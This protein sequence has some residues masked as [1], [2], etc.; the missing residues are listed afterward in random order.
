MRAWLARCRKLHIWLV[1][2][3]AFLALYF[4]LRKPQPDERPG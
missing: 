2:V 1:S 4:F 3:A